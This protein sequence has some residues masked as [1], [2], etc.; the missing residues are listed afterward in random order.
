MTLSLPTFPLPG[1][2]VRRQDAVEVRTRDHL[3][4]VLLR[5]CRTDCIRHTVPKAYKLDTS[6]ALRAS[7]AFG[8][9]PTTIEV[10]TRI[11]ATY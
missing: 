4:L 8:R 11:I 9:V 7:Q 10:R 2:D 3:F 1:H 5:P 6:A